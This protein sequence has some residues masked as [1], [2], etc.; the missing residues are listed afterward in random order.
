VKP[1]DSPD[2][3]AAAEGLAASYE[4][5]S[6]EQLLDRLHAIDGD[7]DPVDLGALLMQIG[8]RSFG[9][10][11]LLAGIIVLIPLIGDIPGVPTLAALLVAI[12][13]VQLIAGR[14]HFWLPDFLL[15][16]SIRR[17]QLDKSLQFARKPA[18]FADRFTRMR[19]RVFFSAAGTRL[20]GAATLG[21]ALVMPVLELIPFSANLAGIALA[22]FGIAIVARDGLF[23][24]ISLAATACVFGLVGYWLVNL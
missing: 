19:L 6:L 14:R 24:V 9:A 3:Q 16:R 1:E 13:A 4:I 18:R 12:T 7:H 21:V 2:P 17:E 23:A 11:L 5:N 15:K 22:A 20:V 8:R 10:I